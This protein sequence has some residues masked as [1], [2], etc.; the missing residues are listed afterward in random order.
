[1]NQEIRDLFCQIDHDN[2]TSRIA[3][4]CAPVIAG[5]KVS[6][7]LTAPTTEDNCVKKELEGT[8]LKC[9]KLAEDR[10][11]STFIVYREKEL[12][13]WILEVS[14]QLYLKE[15]GLAGCCAAEILSRVRTRYQTYVEG[16]GQ[17][18]HEI[19]ILLGYP[20][21]DV[22]GFVV[23]KG[24][25]CLGSGYWKIY[26]DPVEKKKLFCEFDKARIRIMKLLLTGIG[27]NSV[28]RK[29]AP[30]FAET[31]AT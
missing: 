4:Q 14:N 6:N 27:L 31:H 13:E 28:I 24:R 10:G 11:R 18:P 25:N 8:G 17:Y 19:G 3:F 23:N 15:A 12:E 7:L 5:L 1:M 16:K 21:E 29:A 22:K 2:M 9:M 30:V 26:S 20:A